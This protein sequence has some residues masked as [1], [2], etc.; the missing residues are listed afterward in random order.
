VALVKTQCQ[1]CA[2]EKSIVSKFVT[3]GKNDIFIEE[4]NAC[5]VPLVFN[6]AKGSVLEMPLKKILSCAFSNKVD[7]FFL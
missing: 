3:G 7:D 4:L 2:W 1:N 5:E 6:K